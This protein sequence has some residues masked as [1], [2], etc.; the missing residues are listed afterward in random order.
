MKPQNPG[1]LIKKLLT[2]QQLA[3][4]DLALITGLSRQTISS[5]ISGRSGIT[6]D[7]AVALAA[8]FGNK[9]D[10]WLKLD[11]D[12][13]LALVQQ[14]KDSQLEIEH[15]ALVMKAAPIRDMVKRGWLKSTDNFDE[16]E[17]NL[18]RF[19]EVSNLKDEVVFEASYRR[20]TDLPHSDRAVLAWCMRARQLAQAVAVKQFNPDNLPKLQQDLRRIAAF[21][22][23]T[24][25]VP[26]V[27]ASYGI[28]FVVIEPLPQTKVDG[29]AFW[30]DDQSPVIAISIR[31]DRLDHFW[32]TVMH[33]LK[34]IEHKDSMSID[35]G[36]KEA[37][38]D[39]EHGL[40]HIEK[41]AN[42][43]AAS[44]LIAPEEMESFIRRFAPLFSEQR[45]I[46]FAHRIKIH[47][48][49]IVGQLQQRREI[50]Y[51][52]LRKLL[53]KVRNNTI[54]TALTDGWGQTLPDLS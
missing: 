8:A 5:I 11:S 16:L 50:S 20:N 30:L 51:S 6:P 45:V 31:Y 44:S 10:E 35:D 28:R 27:F 48:A 47:P 22:K 25:R 53:P 38:E 12:Y 19:F 21:A 3:Q 1:E 37:L 49:I 36:L 40:D 43:G 15:R 52:T 17:E 23:E 26:Q 4:A 2:D 46:Q 9:P 24:H 41:R 13:R 29:A 7:T 33:E 34:H 14:D 54:Q 42:E 18:K 39:A 32:F